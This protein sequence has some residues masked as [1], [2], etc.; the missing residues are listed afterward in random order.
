MRDKRQATNGNGR[1]A[2]AC[3]GCREDAEDAEEAQGSHGESHG[4]ASP[5]TNR[6]D[7]RRSDHTHGFGRLKYSMHPVHVPD[8]VIQVPVQ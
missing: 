4:E 2:A 6:V 1:L 7:T 5:T 3:R 8:S